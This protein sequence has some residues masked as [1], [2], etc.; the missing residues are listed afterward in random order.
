MLSAMLLNL[1]PPPYDFRLGFRA[2]LVAGFAGDYAPLLA[3][4]VV[5]ETVGKA[6]CATRWVPENGA[7]SGSYKPLVPLA[8]APD[9]P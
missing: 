6:L 5:I 4:P 2:R 3:G 1:M 8:F 7:S 9:M